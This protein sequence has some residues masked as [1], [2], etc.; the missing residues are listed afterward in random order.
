MSKRPC[1]EML[2]IIT[3]HVDYINWCL[4]Y[5][6]S[7][8]DD[9]GSLVQ[10]LSMEFLA[11]IVNKIF[12]QNNGFCFATMIYLSLS[13]KSHQEI[14]TTLPFHL[15]LSSLQFSY[16]LLS[17]E[18]MDQTFNIFDI[19]QLTCLHCHLMSP[20]IKYICQKQRRQFI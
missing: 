2:C 9:G 6:Y 10:N 4:N 12:N 16:I 5:M 3:E 15:L 11:E 19:Y 18:S 8:H 20:L 17:W 7:A 1:D 13:C 14:T